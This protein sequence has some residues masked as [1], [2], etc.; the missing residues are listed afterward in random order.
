[1]LKGARQVY[2]Y[3]MQQTPGRFSMGC[4]GRFSQAAAERSMNDS[5][6]AFRYIAGAVC[7]YIYVYIG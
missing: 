6:C 2:V 1:M 5:P 4:A 7:I 3:V